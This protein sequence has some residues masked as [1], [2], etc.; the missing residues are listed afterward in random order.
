[1]FLFFINQ[2]AA[3]EA[4]DLTKG[5]DFTKGLS[6]NVIQIFLLISILSLAPSIIMIATSFTRFAI[7]FSFLRNAIGTQQSPPNPVITSLALFLTIFVMG[8]TFEKAYHDGIAPLIGGKI[9]ETEAIEKASKPF[10]DF[11]LKNV[12]DKDINLFFGLAKEDIPKDIKDT[13]FRILIPAF[14]V[15][16]LKR[17]FE[18]G[19]LLYVPF[20]VIDI[21]VSCILMSMGMM[22]LPPMII[23]M[24]FKII[25]FVFIDGWTLL[26]SNLVQGYF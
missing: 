15:S 1:M 5:M 9:V 21:L 22:M 17:A 11:M 7:V 25:F 13:P 20:V 14:M 12:K 6:T 24:P 2:A 18:I 19:F 3:S 8:P 23:S 26:C 16:E 4:I 10:H